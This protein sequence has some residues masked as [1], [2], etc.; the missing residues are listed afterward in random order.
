M[1]PRHLLAAMLLLSAL[2]LTRCAKAPR[3]AVVDRP[4]IP[5]EL[6]TCPAR[7]EPPV[8]GDDRDLAG[9]ILDLAQA[10]DVCR[11]HLGAVAGL[12]RR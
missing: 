3:L 9:W 5:D 12:S 6:L 1:R 8:A 4:S 2:P 7:P 10:G 11:S